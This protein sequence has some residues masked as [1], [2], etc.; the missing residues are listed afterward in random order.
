MW[1]IT[2]VKKKRKKKNGGRVCF[3]LKTTTI[4]KQKFCWVF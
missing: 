1:D 2:R 4:K 3:A